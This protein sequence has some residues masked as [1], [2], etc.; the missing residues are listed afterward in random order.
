VSL[1][2][3]YDLLQQAL[4]ERFGEDAEMS[5]AMKMALDAPCIQTC[6]P[7]SIDVALLVNDMGGDRLTLMA[8]LL[9]DQGIRH[10]VSEAEIEHQFGTPVAF[11]V[12]GVN[13]LNTLQECNEESFRTPEQAEK[14]R[15]LL[16]AIIDDVR[17]ML[18][19]LCAR[20]ARMRIIKFCSYEQRRCLAQETLDI[21]APLANRLGM[22]RLK[23]E[24][25]DLAFRALD[26]QAF[27]RIADL[28]EERRTDREVFIEQFKS[29]LHER[30]LEAEIKADISGRAKHIVSIWRKMQRKKLEFHELFDVRAVRVLVD[31]V[32]DCYAVLGL[33]HTNWHSIPQEFDDYIAN[34]KSNGYASLH[35]AVMA[36]AGKVVEV[37]IR[38]FDMHQ[39]SEFGV[40]SHWRY[41]EG[42]SL[43]DSM[44]KSLSVMRDWLN[45]SIGDEPADLFSGLSTELASDR[46]YVFSPKGSVVDLPREAT[47]LDFA[48]AIHTQVG[49]R[50]RGAK[51]NGRIV[52][53]TY[54]LTTGETV[55]ILT[56]KEGG[57]SRDWM[58]KSLGYLQSAGARS[59]VRNWF[60]LLDF[61]HNVQDGKAILER[62]L[63]RLCVQKFS[64]EELLKHFRQEDSEHLYADIGRGHITASQLAG[65]LQHEEHDNDQLEIKK[66]QQ[67][68]KKGGGD[69]AIKIQGVGNLLTTFARCCQPVPG[70]PVIGFITRGAGVSIHKR[71]CSNMLALRDDEKQRL[72]EVNW[73]EESRAVYPVDILV[74]AYDRTG[75]LRD[76]STVLANEHVNLIN[77]NTHTDKREQLAHLKLTIEID[78]ADR[79]ITILD[80]LAQLANVQEVRRLAE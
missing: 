33:V 10:K 75:L 73:G 56:A 3:R 23:W 67:K 46:V 12:R 35:T 43:D 68:R 57:P 70:D 15:R 11:L 20:L 62:E 17:V 76:V 27:K 32:A 55:E 9:S 31:S 21:Y 79:L 39:K 19:K 30:L 8:T 36:E 40:A 47:P 29:T 7:R 65:F 6:L 61:E 53:L 52:P 45:S 49:Y 54:K 2:H 44:E 78:A 80:K 51:I 18:I 38:T 4:Q 50:C 71:E 26:P 13:R 48:F 42:V 69:D 14:L 37:Q 16:L 25:E 63:T 1:E 24:L 34:P 66:S 28:L 41:K 59:K 72:I 58:N 60:N 5:T 77:A 64:I 22:G 74:V